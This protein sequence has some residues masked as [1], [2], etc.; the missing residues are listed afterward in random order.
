MLVIT[1]CRLRLSLFLRRGLYFVPSPIFC[2]ASNR[3]K[4]SGMLR[5]SQTSPW[6]RWDRVSICRLSL[7]GVLR[8]MALPNISR[9]TA[10]MKNNK[11]SSLNWHF[12]KLSVYIKFSNI[13]GNII[14]RKRNWFQICGL[15]LCWKT[16][17]HLLSRWL[18][19]AEYL[20]FQLD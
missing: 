3:R 9:F 19:Y 20:F 16:I 10:T 1:N 8:R 5:R 7:Q 13:T 18:D 14:I 15:I 4:R 11:C 6:F 17:V 2:S 12:P